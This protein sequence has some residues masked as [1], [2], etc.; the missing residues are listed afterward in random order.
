MTAFFKIQTDWNVH[1]WHYKGLVRVILGDTSIAYGE[2]T[3][4][5]LAEQY[6]EP[7]MAVILDSGKE[8]WTHPEHVWPIEKRY[9]R[10]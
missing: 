2:A 5:A 6:Q 7:G 1:W 9:G 8:L 4:E 10:S 3:G